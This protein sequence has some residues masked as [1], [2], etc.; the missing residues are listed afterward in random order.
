MKTITKPREMASGLISS[1]NAAYTPEE[2]KE[3]LAQTNLKHSSI[4]SNP[5]GFEITGY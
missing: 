5:F 4:K 3:I 1:I 2:I